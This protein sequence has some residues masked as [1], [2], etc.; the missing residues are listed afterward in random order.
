M[1][2]DKMHTDLKLAK[3]MTGKK[4]TV[5]VCHTHWYYLNHHNAQN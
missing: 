5:R 4:L 1:I 2:K 3:V